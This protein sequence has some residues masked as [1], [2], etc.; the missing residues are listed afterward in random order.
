M[1]I[2]G[3]IQQVLERVQQAASARAEADRAQ[4]AQRD[5]SD[6][7]VT[8]G[9]NWDGYGL[10]TLITMVAQQASPQ[11]LVALAGEWRRH[12]TAINQAST[13]LQRS[14]D[15]LMQFWSGAAADDAWPYD[16]TLFDR[17]AQVDG[18][19][20]LRSH[21]THGGESGVE[22]Y[23]RVRNGLVGPVGG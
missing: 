1:V 14:V 20:R 8:G 5:E 11:Q 21:V 3:L 19:K 10:E 18:Q 4:R 23:L 6:H 12:G 17:I 7:Y 9:V 13:D 15:R 22:R 2:D 16:E